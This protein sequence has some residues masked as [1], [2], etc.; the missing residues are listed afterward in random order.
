MQINGYGLSLEAPEGWYGRIYQRDAAPDEITRPII[1]VS[2]AP[3]SSLQDDDTLAGT[4]NSMG[5][6]GVTIAIYE[7]EMPPGGNPALGFGD[8]LAGPNVRPED[9]ERIQNVPEN[10]G[11]FVRRIR[12]GGRYFLIR[13][14]FG[15]EQAPAR[16]F[17]Q[18]NQTL[19][20]FRVQA[21]ARVGG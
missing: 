16:L 13:V 14:V 11:T 17:A 6:N 8:V 9:N 4:M 2:N 12:S 15:S 1:H 3:L 21:A 19:G 10:F 18:V 5:A 7:F 20:T